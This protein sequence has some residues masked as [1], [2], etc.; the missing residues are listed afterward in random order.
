MTSRL[1]D[2][3]DRSE[4]SLLESDWGKRVNSRLTNVLSWITVVAISSASLGL[5]ATWGI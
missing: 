4:L 1:H 5:V 2:D 3:R